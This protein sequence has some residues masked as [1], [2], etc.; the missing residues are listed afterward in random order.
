MLTIAT[1]TALSLAALLG[2]IGVVQLAGPRFL[3][4][5]YERWDYPQ[6][7]RLVTG[8]LDVAA[9][10]MILAPNARG[11]GIALAAVLIFGSGVTLLNHRQYAYAAAVT[12]M[13]AA[14][15]PTT[16]AV[17]PANQVRFITN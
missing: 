14:L 17:P 13:M 3:Q 5:Q 10:A 6:S 8:F 16:L 4:N 15:I 11:W 1:I 2:V 7:A 12:V 9:A